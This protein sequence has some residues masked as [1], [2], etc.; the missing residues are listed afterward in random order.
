MLEEKY[1]ISNDNS[2]LSQATERNNR[3][4]LD[5]NT[6]TTPLLF[7]KVASRG[8]N[9][10]FDN[11]K[12]FG[13]LEVNLDVNLNKDEYSSSTISR[14]SDRISKSKERINTSISIVVM[15]LVI[16]LQLNMLE[17]SFWSKRKDRFANNKSNTSSI[18][19]P[20][21]ISKRHK[22]NFSRKRTRIHS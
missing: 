1:L 12:R 22:H 20:R 9:Q 6:I 5:S 19:K 10:L 3:Q 2:R 17:R 16:I 13:A 21:G 15:S 11:K 14:K 8:S 4:N 7:A 18:E